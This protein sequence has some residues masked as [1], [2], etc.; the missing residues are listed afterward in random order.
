MTRCPLCLGDP[1]APAR[2]LGSWIL[3]LDIRSVNARGGANKGGHRFAYKAS[4][5]RIA[6]MLAAVSSVPRATRSD[7][8]RRVI[9]RRLWGKRQR[10]YDHANLVAGCKSLIDAM[11][12]PSVG[13][14]VDDSPRWFEGYYRQEKH[15][16]ST[17]PM[18]EIELFQ[19]FEGGGITSPTGD[20]Q[21]RCSD[22][23]HRAVAGR[24]RR[25]S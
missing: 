13:W 7:G 3:P 20:A 2:W 23:A 11:T 6:A 17:E 12:I 10:A 24:D 16:L 21:A 8:R 4:R 25:G 5:V 19:L 1:D 22:L 15:R 9:I 14:L 18:A